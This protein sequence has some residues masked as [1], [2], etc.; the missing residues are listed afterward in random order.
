M[1]DEQ[2]EN[3]EIET[4]NM[5]KSNQAS[6]ELEKGQ[7]NEEMKQEENLEIEKS[8]Q[9]SLE[10]EKGQTNEEMKEEIS[11]VKMAKESM[12]SETDKNA[13]STEIG[14]ET[15]STELE[16]KRVLHELGKETTI[17]I[18]K[19][20]ETISKIEEKITSASASIEEKTV[21]ISAKSDVQKKMEA[22]GT[23]QLSPQT[24]ETKPAEIFLI[25]IFADN[26]FHRQIILSQQKPRQFVD[27]RFLM[28]QT[29]ESLSDPDNYE[30]FP[31][32]SIFLEHQTIFLNNAT[33]DA[34][35]RIKNSNGIQTVMFRDRKPLAEGENVV[36]IPPSV[37]LVFEIIPLSKEE[38]KQKYS[39][40]RWFGPSAIR[41][42]TYYSNSDIGRRR[43]KDEDAIVAVTL[44]AWYESQPT[45]VGIF[46]VCDGVGG[47]PYGEVAAKVG[48]ETIGRLAVN[49]FL[50]QRDAILKNSIASVVNNWIQTANNLVIKNVQKTLGAKASSTVTMAIIAG[51]HAVIANLG[52]SQ[53]YKF[54]IRNVKDW[55]LKLMTKDDSTADGYITEYLGKPNPN[56]TI[57]IHELEEND[58]LLVTCDG[59]PD[60]LDDPILSIGAVMV[61]HYE[62][63]QKTI[64]ELTALANKM[65]GR[66]NISMIYVIPEFNQNGGDNK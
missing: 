62:D 22:S 44:H 55:E 51:K 1:E 3:L 36:T 25:K 6:L 53:I 47:V 46:I 30:Y 57:E 14:M 54:N 37:D 35:I 18:E 21:G 43:D 31:K 33:E 29:I 52:D 8:N 17:D 61:K 10:Q 56:P 45:K 48:A 20:E 49:Y 41:N 66:D 23:G 24:P 9:A 16:D 12:P 60:M 50:Q 26:E 38:Y 5:E 65:G 4:G 15:T 59:L 64:E 28:N 58:R 19:K 7:T 2:E 39:P 34:T 13:T 63:G 42:I 32:F 40:T 27:K 11:S